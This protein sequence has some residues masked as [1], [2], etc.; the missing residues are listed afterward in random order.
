MKA[1]SFAAVIFMGVG[2][3]FPA[4]QDNQDGRI[5]FD[6]YE[7]LTTGVQQNTSVVILFADVDTTSRCSIDPVSRAQTIKQA[8]VQQQM[9]TLPASLFPVNN[10]HTDK[11]QMK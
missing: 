2:M 8:A 7:K 3:H 4:K 11:E 5:T 9:V 6:Y 1:L 10:N